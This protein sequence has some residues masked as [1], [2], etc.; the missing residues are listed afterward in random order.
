MRTDVQAVFSA[1]AAQY[2]RGNPLLLVEREDTARLLPRLQGRT[3]LD[4]GC[5]DGHYAR[6][7]GTLGAA[8]VL[9]LD[10]AA[11]MA[12]L[13]PAP[14]VVADALRLPLAASSVEV[15]IAALVVSHAG[16]LGAVLGEA[17]RVLCPGGA[18]VLSDLHPVASALGWR[19]SFDAGGR[20]VA[21]EAP[22]FALPELR[23]ALAAAGLTVDEWRE[24]AI[25]DRLEPEFRRA[26]RRDFAALR[27]TP[28]LVV[29]RARKG[30]VHG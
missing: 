26:G 8:R 15:V 22:P 1:A 4:L 18:L 3:V 28:L 19:R 29:V 30:A 7:A 17:A 6:L 11:P 16:D 20:S 13:A 25:D 14:A 21:V 10:A 27:G 2:G 9:A 23:G 12:A 5:G 24:P